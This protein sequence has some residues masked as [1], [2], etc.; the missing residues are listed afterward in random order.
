MYGYDY[1]CWEDELR[2]YLS[3]LKLVELIGNYSLREGLY[4][5]VVLVCGLNSVSFP[6]GSSF[7]CSV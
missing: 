7:W 4:S 6:T 1:F 2:W 5:I 3:L